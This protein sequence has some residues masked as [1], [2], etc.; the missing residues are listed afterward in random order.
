LRTR[1]ARN[2]WII[3]VAR[4]AVSRRRGRVA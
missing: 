1:A 3:S 4:Q 2:C